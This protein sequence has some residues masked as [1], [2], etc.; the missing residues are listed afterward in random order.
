MSCKKYLPQDPISSEPSTLRRSLRI[1]SRSTPL[2]SSSSSSAPSCLSSTD[3]PKIRTQRPSKVK[4]DVC[5]NF[6]QAI[7]VNKSFY[8]LEEKKVISEIEN[9]IN[10]L[11]KGVENW[12]IYV[13]CYS[14]ACSVREYLSKTKPNWTYKKNISIIP[15]EC[16]VNECLG[17]LLRYI[18]SIHVIKDDFVLITGDIDHQI[19]F[20]R[21]IQS[22]HEYQK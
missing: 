16:S 17:D 15:I 19:D 22:H 10:Y 9:L 8:Y 2:S 1:L 7:V 5:N 3:K 4:E 20:E 12:E 18:D 14:H 13:F 21:L 6:K 11:G